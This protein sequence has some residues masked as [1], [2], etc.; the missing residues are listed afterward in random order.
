MLLCYILY[1]IYMK[2]KNL[3]YRIKPLCPGCPYT[4]GMVHT[5]V[6]PCPDCRLNGY[7]MYER[8]QKQLSGN[9]KRQKPERVS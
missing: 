7:L 3:V 1:C 2:I 6:N 9:Y 8:F 4:L 5:L